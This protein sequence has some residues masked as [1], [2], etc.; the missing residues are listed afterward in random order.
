MII[1]ITGAIIAGKGIA[2]LPP[3]SLST[4]IS[5]IAICFIVIYLLRDK[6]E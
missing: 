6:D 3:I 1:N 4:L 5:I 2:K